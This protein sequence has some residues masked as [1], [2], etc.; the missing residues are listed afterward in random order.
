MLCS[1]IQGRG[2]QRK[3]KVAAASGLQW[4]SQRQRVLR[5]MA[6]AASLR[7]VQVYQGAKPEQRL[8]DLFCK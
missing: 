1:F 4:E 8:L 7:L 2:R 6:D 3:A 5:V